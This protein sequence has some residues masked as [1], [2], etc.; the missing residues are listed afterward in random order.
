LQA[1][2]CAA[3]FPLAIAAAVFLYIWASASVPII[4]T[5]SAVSLLLSCCICHSFLKHVFKLPI[6]AFQAP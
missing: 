5:F 4:D 2:D 3:T 6:D 1:S